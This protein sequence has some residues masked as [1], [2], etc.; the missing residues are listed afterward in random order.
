MELIHKYFPHLSEKQYGQLAALEGLYVEWNTQINVISRK[1]LPH[2]Y[3]K[4]VLHSLSIAKILSFPSGSMVIDIGT[5]GGFPG[6]PLA[7]IFP[8][9]QFH[10]VDS[11]GK[12][13]KVVE[14]ISNAL[15]LDNITAEHNRAEK[16]QHAPFDFIVTRA[17]APLKKLCTWGMPLLN[18]GKKIQPAPALIALKGGN[19]A[20][21]ISES[22]CHPQLYC[23]NDYFS[24]DY[25]SEKVV[26]VVKH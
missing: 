6:I 25:F 18:K 15:H 17:V 23:I 14:A 24:E 3:E 19:L 10:L 11:I 8:E 2:L 7:I 1:D 20:E 9:V 21:E 16:I 4:H 13:I 5:G 26:L 22:G 12:K